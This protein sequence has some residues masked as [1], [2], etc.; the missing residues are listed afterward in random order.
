MHRLHLVRSVAP[1]RHDERAAKV[2]SLRVRREARNELRRP[3]PAPQP[4]R[5]A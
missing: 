1:P 4:P 3:R 5:A 2:I